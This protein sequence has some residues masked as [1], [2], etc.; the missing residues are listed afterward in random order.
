MASGAVARAWDAVA[1][2]PFVWLGAATALFICAKL[3][4]I[5]LPLNALG[6]PRLGDDSLEYL[7]GAK[8]VLYGY[9]MSAP[10]LSDIGMQAGLD[11]GADKERQWWRA[12]VGV[13]TLGSHS[14]LYD[15]MNAAILATGLPL[16]WAFAVSEAFI[17]V[18]M[19]LGVAMFLNVVFGAP[20]AALGVVL[21]GFAMLPSQGMQQFI[22]S[23]LAMSAALMLWAYMLRARDRVNPAVVLAAGAALLAIHPMA[24]IYLFI[25]VI[26][27]LLTIGP[28]PAWWRRN[29]VV[30]TA[31]LG[32]LVIAAQILP[33]YVTFLGLNA[34]T[35]QG[36]FDTGAG[37]IANVNSAGFY[38]VTLGAKYVPGILVVALIAPF[39]AGREAI[40][41]R[42]LIP[43]L[44]GLGV[45]SV[46]SLFF[47]VPVFPAEVF[48]R[49]IVPLTVV[50]AGIAG[51]GLAA[52]MTPARPLASRAG[53][54]LAVLA[55]VAIL[56]GPWYDGIAKDLRYRPHIIDETALAA[57]LG[58]LPDGT[59]I[60]YLESDV[61]LNASLLAGGDRH[62]ALVAHMLHATPSLIPLVKA[63]KPVL[64]AVPLPKALNMA[65]AQGSLSLSARRNGFDFRYSSKLL[66]AATARPMARLYLWVTNPGGDSLTLRVHENPASRNPVKGGRE[67]PI[68]AGHEGWVRIDSGERTLR[69]VLVELPERTGWIEGISPGLP[70]E[71]I[72]WPWNAG[73]GVAYLGRGAAE[74]EFK[75]VPFSIRGLFRG[76]GVSQYLPLARLIRRRNPVLW[77]ATGIVFLNTV[78]SKFP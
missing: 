41:R 45:A 3:I 6:M 17:A 35:A 66:I 48:S 70:E 10:A 44:A 40:V 63:R 31:G 9:D 25:G 23:T 47:Y 55:V 49:L 13:K 46:V 36:G 22:A 4:I 78:Y 72:R 38:L 59:T 29:V 7:W 21:L 12:R 73:L 42:P 52:A 16:K 62:G 39:V 77:D 60:F 54:G 27:H 30:T 64:A 69:R 26:A 20:A 33:S 1:R 76:A 28:S 18:A 37:L 5:F 57:Q 75:P 43:V 56:V 34:A 24:P 2:K 19:G 53:A 61:T 68:S 32:V 65:H 15:A 50:F 74:G 51:V 58:L 8:Q 67:I 14:P 11:D 71:H